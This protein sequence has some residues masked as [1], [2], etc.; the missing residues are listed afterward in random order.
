MFLHVG[1]KPVNTLLDD[2][3]Q[4]LTSFPA[5]TVGIGFT[6]IELMSVAVHER[7]SLTDTVWLVLAE[8]VVVTVAP[9]E[10]DKSS[11]R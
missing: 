9:V 7:A 10:A 5:L 1:E 3:L 4:I 6:V 2:P 11:S 8:G